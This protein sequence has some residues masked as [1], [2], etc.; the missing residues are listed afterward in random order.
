MT[1]VVQKIDVIDP[2]CF[3]FTKNRSQKF[4]FVYLRCSLT[5]LFANIAPLTPNVM[6]IASNAVIIASIDVV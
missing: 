1:S 2:F 4:L 6:V 3:D 5:L